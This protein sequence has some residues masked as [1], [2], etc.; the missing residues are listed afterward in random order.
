MNELIG[1]IEP[2]AAITAQIIAEGPPGPKGE[3]GPAGPPGPKGEP[4]LQGEP[5]PAGPKGDTGPQGEPGADAYQKALEHGYNRT[6]NYFYSALASV[7]EM[8]SIVYNLQPW[9][10]GLQYDVNRLKEDFT[11][12]ADGKTLLETTIS[13]KGGTVSKVDN[14]PTFQELADGIGTLSGGAKELI[15]GTIT[16]INIP[17]G[18]TKLRNHA[19]YQCTDL[20]V[21]NLPISIESIG[22]RCFYECSQLHIPWLPDL[23]TSIGAYAF[24]FCTNLSIGSLPS[25]LITIGEGAFYNCPIITVNFI[26]NGVKIIPAYA[27]AYCR[28]ITQMFLPEGIER[29]ANDAFHYCTN[30]SR[31]DCDF[32]EGAVANAPW[33]AT[34]AT[35]TYLR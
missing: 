12:V 5:G 6:E 21:V 27:F 18:T 24:N 32:A 35:I 3:P 1:A 30:L 8:V 14:V 23:I 17:E 15:E 29:I 10:D 7:D 31:I 34:K 28:G 22:E 4:G 11:S 33:G 13:D 16:E 19:F 2:Q 25:E 20:G 26:P 9:V